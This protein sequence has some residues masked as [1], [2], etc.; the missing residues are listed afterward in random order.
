MT[1][2]NPSPAP[3]RAMTPQHL[4][5]LIIH[6]PDCIEEI[7][8]REHEAYV[9]FRRQMALKKL[10]SLWDDW[11]IEEYLE[12]PDDDPVVIGILL[13]IGLDPG[14]EALSIRD[15]WREL[16]L[17]VGVEV[18][19]EDEVREEAE[20]V[21][22]DGEDLQEGEEEWASL[23]AYQGAEDPQE[24]DDG[25]GYEGDDEEDGDGIQSAVDANSDDVL[26]ETY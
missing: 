15:L 1:A 16:D 11:E 8:Q 7:E 17:I 13:D 26:G 18:E 3:S 2:S 22:V 9:G 20:L 21:L 6:Q 10:L 25:E 19:V 4:P 12:L 23:E 5:K 14:V 24:G